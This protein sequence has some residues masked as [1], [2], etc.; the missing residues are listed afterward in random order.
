M[1]DEPVYILTEAEAATVLRCAEED[2]NMLDLLPQV[3]AY[4]AT[5]TGRDWAADETIHPT[6]KSA[7]RMLLVRWHEDPGGMAAGAA[8]GFGLSA[9][10]SQLEAVAL[11]LE[12]SGVPD[13][14]LALTASNPANGA[15]NV[16][17]TVNPTLVFNHEMDASAEE[18]ISLQN[19]D[20]IEIDITNALDVTGKILTITPESDL[21]A[22]TG[23]TLVIE[24]A[25]DIYGQTLSK[26]I[27]F[28]T[29]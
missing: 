19:E 16:A 1:S 29:A 7:A 15:M 27:A 23:Y 18:A 11:T 10:L 14:A 25:A 2:E 21:E 5:A 3:D 17:V 13:E 8:L 6:A 20:G 22:D 26:E 28:T 9:A 12:T 24:A 4:I